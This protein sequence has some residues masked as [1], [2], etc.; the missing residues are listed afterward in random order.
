MDGRRL[1]K[2]VHEKAFRRQA[3]HIHLRQMDIGDVVAARGRQFAS[4]YCEAVD[5]WRCLER[6]IFGKVNFT[7]NGKLN[8]WYLHSLTQ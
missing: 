1:D 4:G 3:E 6:A 5:D 2:I 7:L 8:V